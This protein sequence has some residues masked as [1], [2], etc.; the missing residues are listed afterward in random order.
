MNR[1]NEAREMTKKLGAMAERTGCA[2]ILVGHMNKGS[3]AKAAEEFLKKILSNEKE[4]P[5]SSIFAQT[6]A[7]GVSKRTVENV[8]HELGVKSIKNGVAWFWKME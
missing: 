2:V 3:G 4:V 6:K 8:K 7:I 5:V 1:A